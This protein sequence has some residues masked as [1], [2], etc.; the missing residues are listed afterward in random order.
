MPVIAKARDIIMVGPDDQRRATRQHVRT[1]IAIL[2]VYIATAAIILVLH[3]L[4][5]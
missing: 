5:Q 2:V 1:L 3:A 4:A